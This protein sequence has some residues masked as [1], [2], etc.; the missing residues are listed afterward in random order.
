M[1]R[2]AENFRS[3]LTALGLYDEVAELNA[4]VG[5]I[6]NHC[7]I[8]YGYGRLEDAIA[9]ARTQMDFFSVTGHFAWPDMGNDPEKR[10][11][12]DVMDY[13]R[14]GFAKLRKNWPEYMRL[15]TGSEDEG[16]IPFFSYEYH[17]FMYGDYTILC[18]NTDEFLP[19]DPKKGEED[20]RLDELL[21]GD[22]SQTE[23]FLSTPHHIGYKEGYRGIS[24]SHFNE[25]VSPLVE[26]VSMHGCAES[27]EARPS[28][29]HTM[30]PRSGRNTYQGG[31]SLG[32][33]F[34]VTGSTDHHNAAPGSYGSG[35]TVVFLPSLTRDNVWSALRS[36]KTSA[37]SGDP[38]ETLLIVNGK[39]AGEI[40]P[41]HQGRIK[42]DAFAAGYDRLEKAELIQG[43]KVIA[44][45]YAFEG[46]DGYE[47]FLSLR[48]GWGKKHKSAVWDVKV[49]TEK[50]TIK[51]VTGR[52]RGMDM[53]DPLD[54]P[55]NGAAVPSLS[56]EN[57]EVSMHAVTD[58]NATA[59][60]DSAQGMVLEIDGTKSTM[61][62][63]TCRVLWDGE[64]TEKEY[65]FPLAELRDYQMT[66]YI[67]GFVSPALE[68][69]VFRT[70]SECRCHISTE[71]IT[72]S[73]EAI[74]FRCYEKNG[75]AV[76]TSPVSFR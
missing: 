23:R 13:H 24:W 6:H 28:Y 58:G 50:G 66:E 62:I 76:F 57:G 34:G 70:G 20:K 30:G 19:P 75:D 41:A 63:C 72:D 36:R 9:F 27:F 12:D 64:L 68:A 4:Y 2:I 26:I 16:H 22:E 74:Y 46:D 21:R 69:G 31:L 8:S 14:K 65:R 33:H 32:K 49:R 59:Q 56:F 10:I 7:G 17:S 61:I 39:L 25:A 35:R 71:I 53:V 3:E 54:A 67:N 51:S 55:K 60:T 73:Q 5:D 37:A 43:G 40:A 29:L 45:Q 47:G 38:I 48:F 11:P 42:I 18:R 52:L 1:N 15:M 44:G